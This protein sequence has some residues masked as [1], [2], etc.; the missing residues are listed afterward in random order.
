MKKKLF[1]VFSLA[2]LIL[3]SCNQSITS[4]DSST[5]PS[6]RFGL[7][8]N[9]DQ[10]QVEKKDSSELQAL[11]E[12]ASKLTKYSYETTVNITGQKSH[13]VDYFSPTAFYEDNDDESLSFGYGEEKGTKAVFKY[14]LSE[15]KKTVNNSIYEYEGT[16]G[17]LKKLTGLYSALSIAN[18]GMLKTSMEDFSA[19]FVSGNKYI[20]TDLNT[21]S[22]FQYMT[23][24]GS[25]LI[26][27]MNAVYINIINFETTEFNVI[28]DCGNYGTIES[29][30]KPI[31]GES[32]TDV[33]EAGIQ[34]G[35]AK[36]VDSYSDVNKFLAQST[37][38]DYVLEGIKMHEVN[39]DTTPNY[40]IHLT[41]DYFYFEYLNNSDNKYVNFG[42]AF[43]KKGQQITVKTKQADGTFKEEV[44]GPLNYDACFGFEK[45]TDG[46]F[47]FDFFKGPVENEGGQKYQEVSKLPD[48]GDE[49]ILYIV[50][51]KDTGEKEVW[52]WI[53]GSDGNY[54]WSRYSSWYD[55]VGDFPV[56]DASAT[57]YL[58]G[59]SGLT[60]LGGH[61][62]EKNLSEE[63][64]YYAKEVDILSMLAN[65]LFGWG[66]Q[67]T[68][69]WISYVKNSFLEITDKGTDGT[70]NKANLG[71]D[72]QASVDG[73]EN[74]LQKIFYTYD[75][76]QKGNVK[77][78]EDFFTN[79]G[80]ELA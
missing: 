40:R 68:T 28:V 10:D 43:V 3:V 44:V 8:G 27:V 65:G 77:E 15:D 45:G 74:K 75:F 11:L 22:V 41:P 29:V 51:N 38:N 49:S 31:E 17:D 39:G 52:E 64:A 66:F 16:S 78:V 73:G 6:D 79:S 24:F 32:V 34:K 70:I 9:A 62:F 69:T 53:K 72:V 46:Q 19:S 54:G 80:V 59:T 50:P 36:G 61:F 48:T 63:N 25:S 13:F 20:L 1:L 26:N 67:P 57:F 35:T 7:E 37:N 14:Y 56:N 71:L 2:P 42:Y 47:F 4:G 5:N 60:K 58:T 33:V 12:Y 21:A 30:F 55:N 23:T 18:I 76:T